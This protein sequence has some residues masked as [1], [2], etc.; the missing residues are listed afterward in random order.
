MDDNEALA[1][2]RARRGQV[3]GAKYVLDDVLGI[4]GMGIV[5]VAV[6]RPLDR[7]VAVKVPRPELAH[8]EVVHYLFRNEARA[9]SRISHRNIVNVLDFGNE[10]GVPYLVMEHIPG[11][12]LGQLL[13]EHGA[14]PLPAAVEIV[15]QIV[16]GLEDAHSNGVVHA[17]V[18]CD[19]VLVQ[20]L[21]DG[22]IVPRLIDFGIARFL[23]ERSA[24]PV[25]PV[26]FVTGTPEYV[27]PEVARGEQPGPAAD[28]YAIGVMLYELVAGK[29]PFG[30][31]TAETIMTLKLESDAAA[32][33][34]R[35]PELEIPAELD[36]LVSR[37]LA[38]DPDERPAN[39]RELARCLD[40]AYQLDDRWYPTT[41]ATASIFSTQA[42]TATMAI[43]HEMKTVRVRQPRTPLS[44]QRL[45]VLE[46]IR[47]GSVDRIA[48]AYLAL[49][50]TLLDRHDLQSAQAE[51]EEGV[52]LLTSP[53]EAGPVW[54]L[55][56]ALAALYAHHG[57]NVKARLAARA[58]RDQAT[59]AGS[60]EGRA[61]S[62]R[63]CSRLR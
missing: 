6:Q 12:R 2:S 20:T 37:M 30:G 58:A 40:A 11:P 62:E 8:D 43:A 44:Q 24:L 10:L 46:A 17:D 52:A 1:R 42:M 35:C 16:A 22:T 34:E 63:L 61:Q 48:A 14:L 53:G 29:A 51:L 15:R 60:T 13:R 33:A 25:H 7:T 9:G 57:E 55:L 39:A 28:V 3:L 59:E 54:R 31:G 18:K 4:G 5:H 50:R 21:R 27:A 38:R 56:L 23:D 41:T 19:N 49:A 36:A 47:D 26:A 32:L 45:A